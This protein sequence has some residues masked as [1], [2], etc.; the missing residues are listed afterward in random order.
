MEL[1]TCGSHMVNLIY[2]I[3][4]LEFKFWIICMNFVGAPLKHLGWEL[5]LKSLRNQYPLLFFDLLD[6][7]CDFNIC[8]I[9]SISQFSILTD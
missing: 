4:G 7:I 3:L 6:L 5:L 9:D 2:E 8:F 1:P